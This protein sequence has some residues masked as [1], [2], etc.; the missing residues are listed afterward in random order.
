[1]PLQKL[2]N[3]TPLINLALLETLKAENIND[4]IDIFIPFIALIIKDIDGESFQLPDVKRLLT[5]RFE[6]TPPDSA[7]KIILIRAKKKNLFTQKNGI[8]FKCPLEIDKLVFNANHKRNEIEDSISR[9]L[10]EFARYAQEAHDKKL[11]LEEVEYFLYSF[12]TDHMSTFVGIIGGKKAKIETKIKNPHFLTASFIRKLEEEHSPLSKDLMT[13][14]KGMILSNYISYADKTTSKKTLENI[15]LYLDSPIILG[16]LGYSGRSKENALTEFMRLIQ[17]L[18]IKIKIFDVTLDEVQRL[19]GIWGEGLERKQYTKFNS[20][21]LEYLKSRNIDK[22]R[23]ETESALLENALEKLGIFVAYDFKII[24][25]FNCDVATLEDTLIKKGFENDLRHDLTCVSRVF[26]LRANRKITTLNQSLDVFVTLNLGFERVANSYL[27]KELPKSS[28][29]VIISE[30]LLSTILWLK[31]PKIFSNLPSKILLANAYSSIYADDKFWSTFLSR[32]DQLRKIGDVTEEDFIIVRWDKTLMDKVNETSLETG[33]D[34][35]DD[36]VFEIIESIKKEHS[37]DAQQKIDQLKRSSLEII[38][39]KTAEIQDV[40][41]KLTTRESSLNSL[42]EHLTRLSQIF[43]H[44]IT[45]TCAVVVLILLILATVAS[46]PPSALT[47]GQ[48]Y[49]LPPLLNNT[50][51]F[52]LL[53]LGLSGSIFGITLYATYVK[54]YRWIARKIFAALY[55]HPS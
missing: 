11:T 33:C 3:H 22:A 36:D 14:V 2:A 51:V 1:M 42:T 13:I 50:S 37:S 40:Q 10:I 48:Y 16:I 4:E 21:T 27:L 41:S 29:P 26:N 49:T 5:K 6:I 17:S 53:V 32:L 8:Y 35:D 7:L 31:N 52:I 44:L 34:F 23:L 18:K 28:I 30:R 38:T 12:L 55:K 47:L 9:I 24:P 54:T 39:S 45:G 46:L 25:E 43:S 15:T 19:F 20:K